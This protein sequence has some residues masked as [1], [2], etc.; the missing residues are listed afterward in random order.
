M[1]TVKHTS[2]WDRA[3]LKSHLLD[4]QNMRV[5]CNDD[6]DN[7][8]ASLEGKMEC[9]L[10]EWKHGGSLRVRPCSFLDPAVSHCPIYLSGLG[11]W[12]PGSLVDTYWE[13]PHTLLL[14]SHL[15][16]SS[17]E[18]MESILPV[19]SVN[20]DSSAHSHWRISLA[21]LY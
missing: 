17:I 6:W 21:T 16:R 10:F 13:D 1:P 15:L 3:L 4:V 18:G 2:D 12:W 11:R 19:G 5:V 7:W 8:D 9:T 14:L 20:E